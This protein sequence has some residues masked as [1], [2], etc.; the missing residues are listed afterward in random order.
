MTFAS[1]LLS[2]YIF[3]R[4][5]TDWQACVCEC[6]H[7]LSVY[8]LYNEQLNVN[9]VYQF[10]ICT[11]N[12]WMWTQFISLSLVQRTAECE[13]SLSVYHL[14]REQLNVNKVYH[15]TTNSW[16]WKQFISLSLYNEQ[17]NVNTVYQF[18]TLQRTA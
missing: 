13:H 15:F 8:H 6:G 7:S 9:I 14:Y 4:L 16:M 18:I 17:L 10:I 12:S 5:Q 1:N 2:F 3:M 11:A